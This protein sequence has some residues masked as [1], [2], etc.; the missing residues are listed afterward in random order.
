MSIF[1]L[2]RASRYFSW[3]SI[4]TAIYLSAFCVS[5]EAALRDSNLWW[6]PPNVTE[7]GKEVDALLMFIF[8]LTTTVFILVMG[9]LI[10]CLFRYQ[11]RPGVPAVYSHGNNTL[12][13]VWTTVPAL[14]FIGL[15]IWSNDAWRKLQNTANM[16]E[17]TLRLE[18]VAEQYGWHIRYPGEDGI[19]GNSGDHLYTDENKLGIDQ[20][21]P[22]SHDDFVTYNEMTIPVNRHVHILLRSRDVIHA[23]YVPEFRLYQD[24]VPGRKITWL[25]FRPIATGRFTIA[26]SQL[27]G[28]GHYNMQAKLNVVTPEEYTAWIKEKQQQKRATKSISTSQRALASN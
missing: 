15:W 2:P 8:G 17:D 1:R 16:P 25:N 11:R 27:C 9:T 4:L 23:F 18:I 6:S 14:I 28:V 19:L 5:T 10:Y 7:G 21:D 24:T 26:C 20:S 22:A 3:G 13:I 12:E